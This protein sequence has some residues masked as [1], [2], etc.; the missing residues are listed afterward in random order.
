MENTGIMPVMDVNNGNGNNWNSWIWIIVLFF[1]FMWGGNGFGN[2][3]NL[4]AEIFANG[5]MTR[6][7]I[8]D[9]FAYNDI[10]NGIRGVQNGLCDGFYAQ[11]T[12]MLNGFNGIQ[13]DICY[14]AGQLENGIMQTGYQLGNQI[15]ENRF[16]AQQCCCDTNRNVDS[17]KYENAQNTC[18]ITTNATANTQRILDKLCQMEANAKDQRI[19]EL[20]MNLQ[21]ANYQLSQQAQNATLIGTLR[22]YPIPAYPATSPYQATTPYQYTGCGYANNVA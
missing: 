1:F 6:D 18:A 12:T 7:Q 5:S 17:V 9:E 10:K 20:Q 8:A 21:T 19:A 11:N 14:R 22:P 15:A 3:G 16:A 4:G 13:R 2:R